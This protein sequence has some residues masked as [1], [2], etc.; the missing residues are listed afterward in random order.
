MPLLPTNVKPAV[1]LNRVVELILAIKSDPLA[2]I[3]NSEDTPLAQL[4]L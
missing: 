3:L 1:R 2:V 4:I